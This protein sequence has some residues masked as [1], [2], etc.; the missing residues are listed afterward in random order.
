MLKAIHAQESKEA[1]LAKASSVIEQLRY[2]RLK[3]AAKVVED[4]IS[5]T[6]TYMEKP[7][8]F[9]HWARIRT[10]NALERLNCE[11]KRRTK[12]VGSFPDGDSALMLVAARCKYVAESQ[13]G[14]R[15]YLDI[16]R[17]EELEKEDL[18]LA[19]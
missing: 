4:G 5:E 19:S 3:E 10:N 18:L 2:I 12:V 8:L 15:R 1:A 11:I 7:F 14:Q 6:L 13:W 17:M 16:S 9:E